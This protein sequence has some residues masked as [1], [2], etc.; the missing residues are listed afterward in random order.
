MVS[1]VY[2]QMTQMDADE[3]GRSMRERLGIHLGDGEGIANCNLQ[4]AICHLQFAI[5]N[6]VP[7]VRYVDVPPGTPAST[8]R[9]LRAVGYRPVLGLGNAESEVFS[10]AIDVLA[11][12][13]ADLYD[14]V[15]WTFT[16]TGDD[17]MVLNAAAVAVH[18]ALGRAPRRL[19]G[20]LT[21][22]HVGAEVDAPTRAVQFAAHA[23]ALGIEKVFLGPPWGMPV[24]EPTLQAYG[25]LGSHLEGASRIAQTARGQYRIE[26]PGRHNL[27]LLW[28][29]VGIHRLPS[30]LQMPLHVTDL[31]G[32]TRRVEATRLKLTAEP[33]FVDRE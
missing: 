33:V 23:L 15:G 9:E 25:L 26:I 29:A 17:P 32:A 28:A 3:G 18:E 12:E 30:S 24:L 8:L 14:A 5:C 10:S 6:P 22:L 20:W 13:T 11:L 21:A 31:T 1:G 7:V 2:P 19:P 16:V 27:Y 4:F